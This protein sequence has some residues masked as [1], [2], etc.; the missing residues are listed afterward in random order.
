[1]NEV[2][3]GQIGMRRLDRNDEVYHLGDFGITTP[4]DFQNIVSRLN[5][6]IYLIVEI[7]KDRL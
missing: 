7:M 6:I 2:M 1:M 5:G 3:I 4:E